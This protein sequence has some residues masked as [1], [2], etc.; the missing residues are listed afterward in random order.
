MNDTKLKLRKLKT[1][2]QSNFYHQRNLTLIQNLNADYLMGIK[3]SETHVAE[4]YG[5][6]KKQQK[7]L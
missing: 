4:V 3:M 1:T 5:K 6:K 2:H 7:P